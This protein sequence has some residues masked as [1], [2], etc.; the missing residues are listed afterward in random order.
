MSI[1]LSR[2][3]YRIISDLDK[4]HLDDEK[5]SVW[6]SIIIQIKKSGSFS[7]NNVLIIENRI[8]GFIDRITDE[9]KI[10][11]YNETETGITNPIDIE[12]AIISQ[13]E[14]DLQME[15]LDEVTKELFEYVEN[16]MNQ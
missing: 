5:K 12:T 2:A 3:I 6:S 4:T 16:S 7:N 10:N 9:E 1:N 14:L 11:L 8:V 15:L 13:V